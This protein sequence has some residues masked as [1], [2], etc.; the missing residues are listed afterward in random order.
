VT[1]FTLPPPLPHPPP[2]HVTVRH[3]PI[4]IAAIPIFIATTA[5][6]TPES[7]FLPEST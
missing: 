6:V 1:V 4:P 3:A 5:F 2:H 7:H